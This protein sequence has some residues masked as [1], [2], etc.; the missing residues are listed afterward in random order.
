MNIPFSPPY[1]DDSVIAEV[2]DSL[3]SGWITTGPKV[4]ALEEEIK[5][6]SGAGEVLCVNSWTTG[7]IMTLRWLGVKA[8]DE[9][10]IPAYTYC[11][12]ALAV[13]AAGWFALARYT[14]ASLD[15][16]QPGGS[17]SS[18]TSENARAGGRVARHVRERDRQRRREGAVAERRRPDLLAVLPKN[19]LESM[20][21]EFRKMT[22]GYV[23]TW[24]CSAIR[25]LCWIWSR[26]RLSLLVSA[27]SG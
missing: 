20:P 26:F 10:I 19:E 4:K 12:T 27:L 5:H 3:R 2:T 15:V 25:L 9:V 17:L 18:G 23:E 11:A 24:N 14:S 13:G 22:V 7:A 6:L 1:I 8:D 16:S 21:E